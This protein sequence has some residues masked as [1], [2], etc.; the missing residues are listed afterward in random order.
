MNTQRFLG[1]SLLVAGSMLAFSQIYFVLTAPIDPMLG[2]FPHDYLISSSIQNFIISIPAMIVGFLL[3]RSRARFWLWFA[4]IIAGVGL[5]Q[6]VIQELWLHY[7]WLPHKYPHLAEVHPPYFQGALW[8]VLVR[9]SWHITLPAAFSLAV[10]LLL[11]RAPKSPDRTPVGA[12]SAAS[13]TT[14]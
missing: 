14:L 9:L 5:W 3:L 4:L 7:Y 10:I 2:N 8:W 12:G 13:R 11:S 1:C 6:S